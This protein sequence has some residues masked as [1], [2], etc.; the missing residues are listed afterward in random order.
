LIGEDETIVGIIGD[1]A[2]S[3][4]GFQGADPSQFSAFSLPG[5]IDFQLNDNRRSTN[6]IIDLLNAIRTDLEQ[7]KFRN[8]DGEK[9]TIYVG[10]ES[11]A[12]HNAQHACNSLNVY[13]LSRDNITSNAMKRGINQ[14][15]PTTNL[16]EELHDIDSNRERRNLII[17]CIKAIELAQQKRFKDAIKEFGRLFG[18]RKDKDKGRKEALKHLITLLKNDTTFRNNSLLDFHAFVT[19]NIKSTTS[20]RT[21]RIKTF[22][23]SYT[24]QQ[25]AVCVKIVEDDSLHRTVHKAKGDEF[26]NVLLVLK[27][28]RDLAFLLTPDLDNKEE[29]R[30]NYVAASRA[31]ERLFLSV[32][33]LQNDNRTVLSNSLIVEDV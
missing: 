16:L 22:Y 5:L 11:A 33:T 1:R 8:E 6:Q 2:Q 9:P 20:L 3:I 7:N 10:E 26:D 32:P 23:E 21:G 27:N 4:Y 29:H 19:A 15:I 14:N 25:L 31:R 28:E 12:L 18:S 24:Y 13:S 30:I 17:A